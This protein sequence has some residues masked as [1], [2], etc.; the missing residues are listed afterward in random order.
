MKGRVLIP[1]LAALPLMA[2]GGYLPVKGGAL[3]SGV[4]VDDFEMLDHP[5]TNAE[6]KLFVDASKY[7]P[8]VHWVNG[9]IPA[10]MENW[11]VIFV[12]R[13]D[14][15]AYTKW[16]AAR[17][18]RIYRLPTRSE[19][20]YAARAGRPDTMYPW[21]NE[22]PEG[23]ANYDPAGKRNL[24]QWRQFLKPVKSYA[25]NPW[26]L[27]DMAGNVFQMADSYSD[28]TVPGSYTFR[29]VNPWDREAGFGGG[30][31][32]RAAVYLRCGDFRNSSSGLRTPEL[33]FRLVRE[34]LGAT[35]FHKQLRHIVAA[36]DGAGGVVVGW[37][38]LPGEQATGFHVY[39]GMRRDAAGERLTAVPIADSTT[40]LDPARLKGAWYRVRPVLA[41]GKEGAP[42]EWA[43]ARFE[44]RGLVARFGPT[45]RQ[46]RFVPAFGDL[47]GDGATDAVLK[48]DNG[49]REN[50]P[51]P[52]S[53]VGIE[54]FLSG[55]RFLW[56]RALVNWDDCFGNPN[57]VPVMIYD[58]DGDGRGEAITRLEDAGV[59]YLAV[60]DGM[61]GRTLAKTPWPKMLTDHSRTSSRIHMAIAYLDGRSPAI[62]IQTGLY[63]NELVD[64][65][66]PR[67]RHLWQ[68]RSVA[69]TSGGGSHHLE[70]ADLDDDGRDEVF[71]GDNVIGPDGKLRW[72]L[73]RQHP[74]VVIINRIL[75]GARNRQAFFGF[76][77]ELDAGV[78]LVDARTGELIWKVSREDDPRW[79]HVQIGWASNIWEGSPGLE[80]MA[81]RD[82]HTEK[83]M[84]LF[85]AGGKILMDPFPPGWQ[86]VNWVGAGVR[87]LMSADGS[88]LGRF[89]GHG[90]E[91]LTAQP[92]RPAGKAAC[93]MA[94]D[95]AGD[96]RDEVVCADEHAVSIYTNASP[97]TRREPARLSNREYRLWTAR[98]IGAGY[99]AYFEWEP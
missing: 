5:V 21:G 96:F 61:T 38:M 65:Y 64:A 93:I 7:T 22:P 68:Y 27:Y 43:T 34:P 83:D 24:G 58:L 20:E 67:L 12:N 99:S 37:Q 50:Q 32:A 92:P 45:T 14:V 80:I 17:D 6:Y 3:H 85:A 13:T 76:E 53:K 1:C 86:P 26:G 69:E 82:G 91:P 72:S 35:H 88:R 9:V 23:R 8:P 56:R 4:R 18:K 81:N 84:A 39:R 46:G 54:A 78:Y 29:A 40:F 52:G 90:V 44:E 15:A 55:G 49:M 16:L 70:I 19:F 79:V 57:N 25:P 71:C 66:D 11:P 74:D 42:S 36:S 62:V 97:A 95:L 30:S 47:N 2:A 87:D 89:T 33:G 10:G 60:L 51:D 63:E 59:V 73:Y 94:A 41:G 48:L 98:N 75:P 31:W 28:T 77:R